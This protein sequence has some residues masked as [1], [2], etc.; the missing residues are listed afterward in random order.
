MST[1]IVLA[2][3][4][5]NQIQH[6]YACV[7]GNSESLSSF[8]PASFVAQMSSE[9]L[10]RILVH[11]P[12]IRTGIV[13]VLQRWKNELDLLDGLGRFW[14][15]FQALPLAGLVGGQGTIIFIVG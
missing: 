14:K 8:S 9:R 1:G 10:E 7:F 6:H 3:G 2:K 13:E 5:I 11:I 12:R 15:H 4:I